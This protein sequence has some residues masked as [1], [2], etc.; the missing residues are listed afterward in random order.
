MP[1]LWAI[2]A[3][4][5]PVA[6]AAVVGVTVLHTGVYHAL[7][8]EDS[9]LEWLEFGGYAAAAALAA[10]TAVRLQ[11]GGRIGL[12]LAF[13]ALALCCALAAGE[14]ISWGQ[15]IFGLDTP[16]EL[17]RVNRQRELNVHNVE[18]IERGFALTLVV[19]SL[20]GLAAPWLVRRPWLVVPPVFLSSAFL[21]TFTYVASRLL[22]FPHPHYDLA[23]YSE[24]PE[25]CFAGALAAFS[26]LSWRRTRP[27]Q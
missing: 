23:K 17:E 12:A 27:G 24:W 19:A 11:R 2:V 9:V 10:W 21:V 5:A 18:S 6:G 1:S 14:E 16:G 25:L 15:R 20:Y 3:F 13:G 7:V 26:F 22:F 8:R 4:V